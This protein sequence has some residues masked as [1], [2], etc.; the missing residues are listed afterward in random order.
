VSGFEGLR[1]MCVF[2]LLSKVRHVRVTAYECS[3]PVKELSGIKSPVS[4]EAG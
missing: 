4:G 3:L 2:T 1:N